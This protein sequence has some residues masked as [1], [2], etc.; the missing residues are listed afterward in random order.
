MLT[1]ECWLG[2]HD[3]CE[4]HEHC[5]CMCHDDGF[6][7]DDAFEDGPIVENYLAVEKTVEKWLE[8]QQ[9]MELE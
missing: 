6:D 2:Y 8:R 1:N 4:I 5:D 3:F 7:W 9:G